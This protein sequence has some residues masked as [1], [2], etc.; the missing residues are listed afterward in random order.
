M[1]QSA[2]SNVLAL[3]P[4]AASRRLADTLKLSLFDQL[5]E[6]IMISDDK[7]RIVHLNNPLIDFLR[8]NQEKIR[9]D[10]PH[11]DVDNLIGQGIDIFHKNATHQRTMLDG[12]TTPHVTSIR[13]GGV[14]FGLKV[15]PLHNSAGARIGTSVSWTNAEQA[16]ENASMVAAMNRALGVIHF[17]MDGTVLDANE[18]FLK[19]LGYTLDEIKG[20]HHRMFVDKT[21]ANTEAY[22]KFWKDLREGQ[23]QAGQYRRIGKG[24]RECWIEASY[25]PILDAEGRPFKVTKFA[26][27]LTPRKKENRALADA[28][29]K[30]V[31]TMVEDVATS[32]GDMQGT[33]EDLAHAA[34]DTSRQSGIVAAATEELA[35]SVNEIAGQVAN[36]VA[37]V[38]EAVDDAHESGRLVRDLVNAA[39][40]I[41]EVT[42]I[43]AEIANQTNLLALNATIEAARAGDAGKGFAVV[44]T[45][46]KTLAAQTAKATE[47]IRAQI[48]GIQN[49]SSSTAD[50]IEKISNIIDRVKEISTAISSAV[51]E[52]S[53]ATQE[54]AANISGVQ[55]SANETGQSAAKVL[56][57]SRDL[58]ERADSLKSN[59]DHFL[60]KVR[61]M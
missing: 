56:N 27:D 50:A 21:Y 32:A 24:G 35:A 42:E 61:S 22:R 5:D 53:A 13:V 1:L 10:L 7:H 38:G 2:R 26:T 15:R 16:I 55:G 44:A 59:V 8:N 3:R 29:E 11:F 6:K 47:E 37:A 57:V 4:N 51:E 43:I 30:D 25:N 34:E 18:N 52:Q 41:G 39:S 23:Y 49:V 46:V 36:S 14:P 58:S 60:E 9:K 48:S 31:R 12:L 33:A 17:T 54:V 45:E 20:K 40:K 28:F 19:V